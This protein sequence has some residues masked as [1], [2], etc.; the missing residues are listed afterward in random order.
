MLKWA[1][2]RCY[3]RMVRMVQILLLARLKGQRPV[4]G[5][6][7]D[8]HTY[9]VTILG[10]AGPLVDVRSR[11]RFLAGTIPTDPTRAAW[12]QRQ[13]WAFPILAMRAAP[14]LGNTAVE[15]AT[16]PPVPPTATSRQ[17]YVRCSKPTCS[18]CRTGPAHGPYSYAYWHAAGTLHK[19]Y[20]GRT[21]SLDTVVSSS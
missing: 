5:A 20:L 1:P 15:P 18:R 10:L 17:E 4:Y 12:A 13:L 2:V 14:V 16:T 19:R 21:H 3:L 9:P 6:L 8:D 11:R 7:V